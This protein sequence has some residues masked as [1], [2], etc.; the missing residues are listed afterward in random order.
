MKT[1]LVYAEDESALQKG[2][3]NFLRDKNYLG[4]KVLALLSGKLPGALTF[5]K[6]ETFR[7]LRP[8]FPATLDVLTPQA[9]NKFIYKFVDA[10]FILSPKNM[11]NT[12]PLFLSLGIEPRK[13][14]CYMGG[15]IINPINLRQRDGTQVICFEGLEFH[16]KNQS[17][18]DFVNQTI[19]RLGRQKQFYNMPR[20][21]YAPLL[22]LMYRQSMGRELDL[23]N[24]K[25]F[26][27]KLSWL[28][29]YDST[30]LKSRLADKYAVRDYV[31]DK[32]GEEY[33]IP[34]LGAWDSFDEIDFD[35][36]P[37]QF[38]LKCNH[39]S[40]M[41]IIVRDKKTFDKQQAREKINAWL[42]TD[43]AML[44]LE[45]H[46]SPI[47]RKI[48]AEKFMTDKE[49]FDL[50]DYKVFCFNGEPA[51]FF[52]ATNRSTDLRF[53]YFD[54][55]WKHTNIEQ[56]NHPNN[57]HPEKIPRPKNF[58]QMKILA[59]KLSKGFSHARID[60]FEINERLYFGEITFLHD[61]GFFHYKSAGTDEYLGSLLRLPPP[62]ITTKI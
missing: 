3:A 15:G 9:V 29:L 17:D 8:N 7:E 32:I 10:V 62:N 61:A 35:A 34:L 22:K 18:A 53:D 6:V 19:F 45:L 44:F 21:Q 24:P 30:P 1:A 60:F 59:A 39:G 49:H 26:T 56:D 40:G 48:I 57:D 33:L 43:F 50:V 51:Y 46:Y 58:E 27:E 11:N 54:M 16:V 13:I 28:K 4:Y 25:T 47:K 14:I 37:N 31:A 5:N 20:E 36:L 23:D 41:N 42:A 52:C 38:V 12:I 2:L 55:N